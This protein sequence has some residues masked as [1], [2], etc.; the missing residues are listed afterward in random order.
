MKGRGYTVYGSLESKVE[1]GLNYAIGTNTGE[2]SVCFDEKDLKRNRIRFSC[3]PGKISGLVY[4]DRRLSLISETYYIDEDNR[5]LGIIS[6]GKKKK[7]ENEFSNFDDY[8][9][10]DIMKV[11]K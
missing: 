4:G 11:K 7:S 1:F 3:G 5:L 2:I 6:W 8:F 9:E 10:G